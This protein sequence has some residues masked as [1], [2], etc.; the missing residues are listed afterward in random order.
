MLNVISNKKMKKIYIKPS[1]SVCFAVLDPILHSTSSGGLIMDQ[2][3]EGGSCSKKHDFSSW[4]FDE[5]DESE[6]NS[7]SKSLWEN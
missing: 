4:D 7:S 5:E 1:V 3:D 6:S 2:N